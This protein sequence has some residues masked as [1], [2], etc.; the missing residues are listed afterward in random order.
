[1]CRLLLVLIASLSFFDSSLSA[2]AESIRLAAI[3][4]KTGEAQ[5]T[6]VEHLMATRFAVEEINNRGG[7]LG[8]P[9][10]LLEF[11]NQSTALGSRNAAREAVA[12]QVQAVVGPSWSSH[13]LAIAPVLQQ[14]GIPMITPL[15]TNPKVTKVGDAIFRAC[16]TDEFQ[17]KLLAKFLHEDIKAERL[18]VLVNTG[19][20]YSIELAAMVIEALG[21]YGDKEVRQQEYSEEITEYRQLLQGLGD[22]SYDAVFIPGYT[23]DSALLVKTAVELGM[24]SAFVG[25]DGWSLEVFNYGGAAMNGSFY[26]TH[27]ASSLPGEQNRAFVD[28][29]SKWYAAKGDAGKAVNAGMALA[30]DSVYLLADAIGRAQS[31]DPSA[32]RKALAETKDFAGLTGSI[33]FDAY[34]NPVKPAV[35]NRLQ[36]GGSTVFKVITP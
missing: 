3:F 9:I 32:I 29:M 31:H 27:W 18:L 36:D 6:S 5:V 33:S 23:R 28:K 30:Y 26:L 7:L 15:A 34:R 10:D 16:F 22:L 8:K 12:A 21:Q 14:A 17:A 2:A 19:Y 35:I 13:A 24:R 1:M 25:G 4:S 20:V 11:D